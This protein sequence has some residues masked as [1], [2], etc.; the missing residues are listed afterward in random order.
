MIPPDTFLLVSNNFLQFVSFSD[1]KVKTYGPRRDPKIMKIIPECTERL[2]PLVKPK[3]YKFGI[4][5]SKEL[6]IIGNPLEKLRLQ[7][8]L[9]YQVSSELPN[10][11][12]TKP[13]SSL[14][15]VI[16]EIS[17]TNIFHHQIF[18][19]PNLIPPTFCNTGCSRYQKSNNLIVSIPRKR[20]SI[21]CVIPLNSWNLASFVILNYPKIPLK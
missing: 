9:C 18:A 5:F 12:F 13:L 11:I 17:I 1:P 6:H 3:I 19:S 16:T 4:Y 14:S 2:P 10:L 8:L 21:T 7:Y 15:C 20:E